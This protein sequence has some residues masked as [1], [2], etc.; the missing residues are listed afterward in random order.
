MKHSH[1]LGGST[2]ERRIFCAGSYRAEIGRPDSESADAMEGTACHEVMAR[3]LAEDAED[4]AR[5]LGWVE[6]RTGITIEQHHVDLVDDAL[7]AWRRIVG[8]FADDFEYVAEQSISLPAVPGAFGTG[9]VIGVGTKDGVRTGLGLDWKFGSGVKVSAEKNYQA[10]FYLACATED[11][12]TRHLFQGVD[13]HLIAIVQPPHYG[14][15]ADVWECSGT[16]LQLFKSLLVQ[17]RKRAEDP[18]APRTPGKWCRWCKAAPDCEALVKH[19]GTAVKADPLSADPVVL[20]AML[21]LR[22]DFIWWSGAVEQA[23][24]ATL[25]AGAD[26]PGYKEVQ[27]RAQRKWGVEHPA[28]ALRE[29]G[30]D[31]HMEPAIITPAEAER[32]AKRVFA[33]KAKPVIEAIAELVT[34]ESSGT[35]IV[36][37]TDPRPSVRQQA[38]RAVADALRGKK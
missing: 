14:E 1:V 25:L 27:R 6:P 18:T 8:L 22:R 32:R 24:H 16:W 2:A 13:R 38:T 30:L 34:K 23:A 15:D 3:A 37:E 33:R 36:P 5:Y 28:Q 12:A 7:E 35:D 26:V 4:G 20:A 10:A 29:L 17:A 19:I 11:P 31:P 21:D 9:D